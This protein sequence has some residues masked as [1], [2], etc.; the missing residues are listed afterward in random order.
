MSRE[1][2][3]SY[4]QDVLEQLSNQ[5]FALDQAAIVAATDSKGIITYVNQKFCDVTGYTEPELIGQ[6][7][8][9]INSGHHP[10]SFFSNLWRTISQGNT[11]HGEICNK[12]KNGELYWVNTTIVPFLGSDGKPVQ[13]LSIRNEITDLKLAQDIIFQQ[14]EKLMTASR[15]GAIGEMAA[16]ITHEINNP[17]S[18]ILGRVEMLKAMID[19]GKYEVSDLRR[20]ADT[21]EI[22]GQRIAKI[23]RSMKSM[24]HH[25]GDEEPY[26]KSTISS[27]L[28]DAFE[29]CQYRFES[30]NVGL[31]KPSLERE[32]WLECRSHQLVQVLVNLL[33]NAFDAVLPLTE[34]WVQ[35]DL[36]ET[37]NEVEISVT[38]SGLGIPE[39]IQEKIF[40]PFFST[41]RV[42]YGTGMGLS[43]SRGIL[44]QNNGVLDYDSLSPHTRFVMKVPRR[45]PPASLAEKSN[46]L[47]SAD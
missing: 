37:E 38:D 12:T 34:K 35:I 47:R 3:T 13:Y 46:V 7:H 2:M 31:R 15:L 19:D 36:K 23:V 33:N 1:N 10:K 39:E 24:A 45:S 17:L 14:Q 18:V 26:E 42:Q 6:N 27:I 28:N 32:V 11:W 44:R 21:I 4:T 9:I 29:L 43:I 20:I 5:K 40:A 41:K 22:T 25:Q 30:K 16:A 8:R